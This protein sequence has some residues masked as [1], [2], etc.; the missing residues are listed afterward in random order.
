M[1]WYRFPLPPGTRSFDLGVKG[2]ARVW[3][4]GEP[5]THDPVS[6]TVRLDTP[7]K[8]AGLGA[9]RIVHEAGAYAGAAIPD[10]VKVQTESGEILAGDWSEQ[11][12]GS[13]SGAGVY[14]QSFVLS[15]DRWTTSWSSTW[16]G[17]TPRPRCA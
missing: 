8:R 7:L 12:L 1:G 2:A 3:V 9:V 10:P 5:Q 16:V 17:S 13:Y 11:G 14:R 6:G 4:N 15:A